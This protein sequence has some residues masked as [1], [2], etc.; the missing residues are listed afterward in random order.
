MTAL[1]SSLPEGAQDSNLGAGVLT[2]NDGVCPGSC[3][4]RENSLYF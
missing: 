2:L 4:G 3:T 1:M